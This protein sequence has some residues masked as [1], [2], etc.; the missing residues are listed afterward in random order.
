M[1]SRRNKWLS[2]VPVKMTHKAEAGLWDPL[3]SQVLI[4]HSKLMPA[5]QLFSPSKLLPIHRLPSLQLL[6]FPITV[7]FHRFA[8]G[9]LCLHLSFS[10]SP[11]PSAPPGLPPL[12]LSP[13]LCSAPV[14]FL[15]MS[16]LMTISPLLPLSALHYSRCLWLFSPSYLQQKSSTFSYHE[17]VMSSVYT[18]SSLLLNLNNFHF[19]FSVH[20]LHGLVSKIKI[21]ISDYP[22][23]LFS[24]NL[25]GWQK[26]NCSL[27]VKTSS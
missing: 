3:I 11:F 5:C 7:V 27:C 1:S 23:P 15:A 18:A 16:T 9:P 24:H 4:M 25:L 26:R 12:P 8:L 14:S 22:H 21:S 17:A 13:G 6:I 2:V 20:P 19:K 10:S